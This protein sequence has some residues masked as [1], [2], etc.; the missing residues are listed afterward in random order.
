M[1]FWA[2]LMIFGLIQGNFDIFAHT[3]AH[4][5]LITFFNFF[6]A[7]TRAYVYNIIQQNKKASD[8]LCFQ[9]HLLQPLGMQT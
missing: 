4:R 1:F 9:L 7:I 8:R 2:F 3:Y 6:L 5:V